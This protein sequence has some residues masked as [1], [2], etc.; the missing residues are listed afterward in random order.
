[1]R[2]CW[3][4]GARA[5]SGRARIWAGAN[6]GLVGALARQRRVARPRGT[7]RPAVRW[8][9]KSTSGRCARTAQRR[10]SGA[11]CGGFEAALLAA[12][13]GGRGRSG[14]RHPA[15]AGGIRRSCALRRGSRRARRSRACRRCF[16]PPRAR[17]LPHVLDDDPA[18]SGRRCA[19]GATS[20]SRRL[21]DVAARAVGGAQRHADGDRDRLERQDHHR[22]SARRLRARARLAERAYCCTDGVF[23]DGELPWRAGTIPV[24][25]AHAASCASTAR[26]AAVLETARGGILRRGH[27]RLAAHASRWSPMSAPITSA[28]TASMIWQGLR[29]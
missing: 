11:R 10:R 13:T 20:R 8:R 19:A 24:R 9:P 2:R 15:G 6:A 7:L 21:P 18:D 22:A 25:R 28:S 23:F 27:R 29:T 12:G 4:G 3:P 14:A 17:G 5:S 16:A 1:M 26:E